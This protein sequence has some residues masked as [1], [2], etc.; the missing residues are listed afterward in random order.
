[1]ALACMFMILMFTITAS[2]AATADEIQAET[3]DDE[4]LLVENIDESTGGVNG[5]SVNNAD[6]E[7]L[8]SDSSQDKLSDGE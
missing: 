5:L 1:M 7:T 8:S 2:F 3:I 4:P 6:D